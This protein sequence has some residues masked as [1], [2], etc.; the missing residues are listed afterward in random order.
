M[1]M[2]LISFISLNEKTSVKIVLKLQRRI[3]T[4][5][6][7]KTKLKYILQSLRNKKC[8]AVCGDGDKQ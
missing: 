8:A 4:E 1:K 2:E 6:H 3:N 7:M 5:S